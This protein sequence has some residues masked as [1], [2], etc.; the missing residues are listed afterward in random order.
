MKLCL[1][2][3]NSY[4]SRERRWREDKRKDSNIR[5]HA[6]MTSSSPVM[7][8]KVISAGRR[9]GYGPNGASSHV[10]NYYRK[11]SAAMEWGCIAALI[12][13]GCRWQR[14]WHKSPGLHKRGEVLGE[15]PVISLCVCCGAGRKKCTECKQVLLQL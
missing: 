7:A 15:E 11:P 3:L 5:N 6:E 1:S 2:R 9:D 8:G 10:R 13:G 14:S 12:A 4:L